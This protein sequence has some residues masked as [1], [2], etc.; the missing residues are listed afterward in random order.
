MFGTGLVSDRVRQRSPSSA[1]GHVEGIALHLANSIRSAIEMLLK[2]GRSED[3]TLLFERRNHGSLVDVR[4]GQTFLTRE[5]VRGVFDARSCDIRRGGAARAP[6]SIRS[7][8]PDNFP[9]ITGSRRNRKT[10][11]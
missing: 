8:P 5:A 11:Q 4:K 9:T 1:L 3:P 7:Q 10:K 6:L 2:S